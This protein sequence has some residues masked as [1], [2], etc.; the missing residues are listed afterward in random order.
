MGGRR[1]INA[2]GPSD[3]SRVTNI[4]LGMDPN[5]PLAYAPG[6]E[7]HHPIMSNLGGHRGQL[8]IEIYIIYLSLKTYMYSLIR[9][10][11]VGPKICF[12]WISSKNTSWVDAK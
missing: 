12:I 9:L 8:Y 3:G 1:E 5:A 2:A 6:L 7:L 4:T 10:V 11:V